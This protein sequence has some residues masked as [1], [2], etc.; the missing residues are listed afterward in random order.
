MFDQVFKTAKKYGF[1]SVYFDENSLSAVQQYVT[2]IRRLLK[3]TC[4]YVLGNRN[5]VQVQ[6]MSEL[7]SIRRELLGVRRDRKIHPP[8]KIQ[9][10]YRDGEF[11]KPVTNGT[12]VDI[13]RPKAEFQRCASALSE[14]T[15]ATGCSTRTTVF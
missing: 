14:E 4:E 2:Y 7:L 5:G 8:Y 3:P 6:K 13:R 15:F 11:R 12:E 1:D 10:D 9:T